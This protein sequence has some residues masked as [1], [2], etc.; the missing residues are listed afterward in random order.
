M[1]N[2]TGSAPPTAQVQHGSPLK[3]VTPCLPPP[4]YHGKLAM[5]LST[6][7]RAQPESLRRAAQSS[8]SSS[9]A[10]DCSWCYSPGGGST[11]GDSCSSS[12]AVHGVALCLALATHPRLGARSPLRLLPPAVL[13]DIAAMAAAPLHVLVALAKG[14]VAVFDARRAHDGPTSEAHWAPSAPGQAPISSCFL[15]EGGRRLVAISYFYAPS[16]G[17]PTSRVGTAAVQRLLGGGATLVVDKKEGDWEGQGEARSTPLWLAKAV[18]GANSCHEVASFAMGNCGRLV[19]IPKGTVSMRVWT[20]TGELV[21]DVPKDSSSVTSMIHVDHRVG[22]GPSVPYI[23][24]F[25]SSGLECWSLE[26]GQLQG[27]Y[28]AM[29]Y[30]GAGCYDGKRFVVFG[31]DRRVFYFSLPHLTVEK[32]YFLKYPEVEHIT[33]V[34]PNS[35]LTTHYACIRI[36]TIND[37]TDEV[38]VQTLKGDNCSARG[39]YLTRIDPNRTTKFDWA[40]TVVYFQSVYVWHISTARNPPTEAKKVGEFRFPAEWGSTS[41]S[42]ALPQ[43]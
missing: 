38:S 17:N 24:F 40:L 4:E 30:G 29:T 32:N 14:T 12:P 19:T 1:G 27:M 11:W 10:V 8:S 28:P 34:R 13:R 15:I 7:Y 23:L 33:F 41:A 6:W 18:T 42:F 5:C 16:G 36:F 3:L 43:W 9:S 37:K 35:F 25:T 21:A 20:D 22:D 2:T 39:I 26:T 31:R